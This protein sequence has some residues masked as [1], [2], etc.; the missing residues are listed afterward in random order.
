MTTNNIKVVHFIEPIKEI[1]KLTI[2]AP[3]QHFNI[4]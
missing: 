4:I 1:E 2:T 3:S